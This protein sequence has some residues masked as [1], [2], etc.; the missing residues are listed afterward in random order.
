MPKTALLKSI[1]QIIKTAGPGNSKQQIF[2]AISRLGPI[3]TIIYLPFIKYPSSESSC[4]S[5]CHVFHDHSFNYLKISTDGLWEQTYF[6]NIT[7]A[8]LDSKV[9]EPQRDLSLSL[10]RAARETA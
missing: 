8:S 9:T 6:E 2:V 3:K 1:E 7:M 10:P 5:I 4:N